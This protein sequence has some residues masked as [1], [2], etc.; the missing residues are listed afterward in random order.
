MGQRVM[1]PNANNGDFVVNALDYLSGSDALI[2]LRARGKSTRP[3]TL[4]QNIRKDAE[5]RFSDKEAQLQ[6]KLVNAQNR[7]NELMSRGVR[8]IGR[9][10]ADQP[11][12]CTR[13]I[14]HRDRRN[15]HRVAGRSAR[16]A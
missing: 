16:S 5:Q 11:K 15:P 6:Q 1:V 8:P 3:F 14:A 9:D 2:S 10:S 13:R 12:A 7:L 4:V